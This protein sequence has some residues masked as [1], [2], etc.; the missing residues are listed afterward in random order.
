MSFSQRPCVKQTNVAL[1]LMMIDAML[2]ICS[3]RNAHAWHALDWLIAVSI[4]VGIN[5]GNEE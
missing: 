3:L 2:A 4:K 5:C 1:Y